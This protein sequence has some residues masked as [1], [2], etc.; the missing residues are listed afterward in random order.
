MAE[1]ETE[2]SLMDDVRAAMTE[3]SE[4]PAGERPVETPQEAPQAERPETPGRARDEHGRFAKAETPAEAGE[5][6]ERPT[7]TLKEK[8]AEG[9]QPQTPAAPETGKPEPIAAPVE[10]RG[11][12]KVKWD[13]LPREVQA[14]IVERHTAMEQ[15]RQ[16]FAPIEQAI[17]PHKELW[18]R[19][20]GSVEAAIGQLAQF[21]KLYL[22]N[23]QGL[24]QHIARTRGIDLGAP[25]GQ[26]PQGAPPQAP[27]ITSLIAQHVQQAIA[28]IQQRF[29]QTETQ[30]TEQT[31][32][33][34]A[35]DPR[36]PYFQDV[37]TDMGRLL[38]AGVA[39]D[40]PDAYEKAVRLNPAIQS[41]LE[42]QRT[43]DAKR[44]QAAEVEKAQKAAAASLRGSPLPGVTSGAT[45]QGATVHDDVRAALAELSGA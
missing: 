14:E 35:A 44:K 43:E 13:R 9:E 45:S 12:A 17:A 27:D 3:V 28:P 15:Q 16:A 6:K 1:A 8:P 20:A 21:Y 30:Q 41:A 39:K 11:A 4:A 24:I 38:Q 42:A 2:T 23:P 37:R 32:A 31:L 36:Y 26:Q 7:L 34:F 18:T 25:Q 22:D 10:W 29:Q 33:A 19:D 40:L 5:P